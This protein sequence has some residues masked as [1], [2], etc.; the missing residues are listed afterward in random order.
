MPISTFYVREGEPASTAAVLEPA[1]RL[2]LAPSSLRPDCPADQ[3]LFLWRGV[4]QPPPATLDHPLLERLHT[5]ASS[6]SLRDAGSYGS[7]LRK[8]HIFCDIFSVPEHSRLP[9]SFAVLH[10][11]ALW[12]AADPDEEDG[13]LAGEIPFEPLAIPTVFKYLS[14]IRAWHLAQGWPEPLTEGDQARI[15]FSLRGLENRQQGKR[16]R[17]PR[18][19]VT[20]PMLACLKSSLNLADPFEACVWAMAACAFWGMMRFGE[21]SVKSRPL[22][23]PTR[24]LTRADAFFGHDLD[25]RPYARLSL[26][27]AKTAR[28]GERQLVF[29]TEQGTICPL[30]ALHNLAAVVPARASDPLFSWRDTNGEIRPAVTTAVMKTINS[31]FGRNGFGT[32]F[33]HSFRIGGASFFLGQK[34]DPEVVRLAGR[35]RSLAYEAYVRAFEQISSQHMANLSQRYDL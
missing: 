32:S 1:P 21:V 16:K 15:G 10:S 5:I 8:Y 23:S 30:A 33:G 19:P 18:P 12:A 22:F 11:F 2:E 6:F 13:Q 14:G 9:A 20:L 35:W 25:G 3:R 7:A 4:N 28:P 29:L 24:H 17:P 27:S 34:V 31:I 26:P